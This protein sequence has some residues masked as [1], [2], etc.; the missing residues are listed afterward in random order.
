MIIYHIAEYI[1]QGL[2]VIDLVVIA[3]VSFFG[4]F[5]MFA[6]S[7]C[8]LH[9]QLRF[10]YSNFIASFLFVFL[11]MF[12]SIGLYAA[13]KPSSFADQVEK[14][15]PSVVNISTTTVVND[16]PSA[17]MP[18]FPP[19]SPFE[20]FFKNFGDN[21]R[22]RKA[23][24]LGS[25]FVIDSSGIVVTNHHVIENAEEIRVILADETSFTAKVLGQDKKTDIAVLKIEPGEIKLTAVSFGDSDR[26]RVGDWVLAIGNPF[27]LGGTVTA[28]IVS[29][30]GRD[31]GNGPYDDFIQTDA[32]IN[33]GNSGGPLFNT[34]GKVIGINTAIYS[35]S[36]GSVGIGFAISSN[37]ASRV[38]DQLI[39][40]GQTRR[41]WLG[42]FIQEVTPDIAESLG[43]KDAA[44]ALVSSVNESS[45]AA[46]GGVQ[47]GDVILKFDG[48]VIGKMRD[49]PRIVAET[50]IGTKVDVELFRQ[51]K[52]KI[53]EITLGELEKAELVGLVGGE[54]P[55]EQGKQSFGSLGFSVQTL[56]PKLAVELG[57]DEN[58][59][60][61]VVSE[62]VQGSPAAE[63]GLLIGDILRRF[64]QRTVKSATEL[65]KDINGAENTSQ[66]GILI[67]IERDGRERFLQI[68]FA[69]K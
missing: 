64:G 58:K 20:E 40:F 7:T 2:M 37:L 41:G 11:A 38:A 14:L 66:T 22:Q 60:G 8:H 19:G 35:Q 54:Q 13:E 45:P 56:S 5:L 53:L 21:D 63:K 31:I 67:L 4:V 48:K 23:Q 57:L 61:V 17:E 25:G 39:E 34:A 16:R 18:Q 50:D 62:V 28:G 15:S 26:L 33:R 27:G 59:T 30:R 43:L 69:K 36:G 51:G 29:A 10:F 52:P 1:N 44:G 42:V 47:P 46:K 32:S 24:S 55:S 49:L 3:L 9:N 65:A 6:K 12:G 68:S